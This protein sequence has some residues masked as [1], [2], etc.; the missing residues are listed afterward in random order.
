MRTKKS[1]HRNMAEEKTVHPDITK[2]VNIAAFQYRY[3]A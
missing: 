2:K 3:E 1:I